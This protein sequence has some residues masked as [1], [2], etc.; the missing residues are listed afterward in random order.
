MQK[1]DAIVPHVEVEGLLRLINEEKIGR[2]LDYIYNQAPNHACGPCVDCCFS[3]A[4]VYPIE[5]LNILSYLLELDELTQARVARKLIEYELFHL[6]TLKYTCP[7]LE[8]GACIIAARKP[9]LCRFFGLYPEDEYKEM[10]AKSRE[11][12][13]RLAMGYA[14]FHR[15]LLQQEVM[16]YDVEQCRV[17]EGGGE[18][19]VATGQER[20]RLHQQIYSLSEQTMPDSWLSLDMYRVSLQ[21]ALFYFTDEELEKVRV[22]AI[23]EFQAG[24]G[25]AF[26]DGLAAKYG[27]RL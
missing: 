8:N 6:A 18:L 1:T 25:D 14:R 4:Q 7:F 5:F 17:N 9:L 12:N 3:C 15:I 24:A 27:F 16:T 23:R 26:L 19:K 11:E 22:E 21:Y 13:E 10:L 20:E 2:R